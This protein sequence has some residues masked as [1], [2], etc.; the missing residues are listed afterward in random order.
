MIIR[1]VVQVG[2]PIIRRKSKK[3]TSV[4]SLKIKKT[5]RD[6][7]QTMRAANLVG[8]SAPQIG[9]NLRV[10]LTEI[11]KTPYRKSNELD[12]MRIFINPRITFMSKKQVSRYE[13]C[14]SVASSGIFAKV[15]RSY[16]I[17]VN[18]V[19]EKN[20]AFTLKVKGLL[21]RIIQHEFDHLEGIIFLDRV[22][23]NKSLMSK[24]EYLKMVKNQK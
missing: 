16:Q 18:A 7:T 21:A 1:S 19:N 2:N 5:I 12:K 15:P 13:G 8:I 6:L 9:L 24:E 22:V 14:G 3:V 23:D 11:R 10:L 17:I 20:E 4:T